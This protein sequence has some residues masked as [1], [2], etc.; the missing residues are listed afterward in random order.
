[1]TDVTRLCLEAVLEERNRQDTKWGEQNHRDSVWLAILT[2]EVGEVA[3]AILEQK[4]CGS[5]AVNREILQVAAVAV[6]WI[7]SRGRG[8]EC[9]C[10]L[11]KYA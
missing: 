4:V 7:E 11:C 8:K 9:A 1:M 3:K 10:G 2:E 5:Q 6:A